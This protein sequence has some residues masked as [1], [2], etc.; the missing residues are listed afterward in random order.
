[1]STSHVP[2]AAWR[3]L[4]AGLLAGALDLCLALIVQFTVAHRVNLIRILQ[5]IA[6]GLLGPAARDGGVGSAS[7]GLLLHLSIATIWAG[8]Y[9]GAARRLGWLSGITQTL[10][11]RVTTG[12]GYGL[13]VWAGMNLVVVPLSRAQSG[14]G[15]NLATAMI[16][17]GHTLFVGLP[18]ALAIGAVKPS[19]SRG[20][21]PQA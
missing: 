21:S 4:R 15:L 3:V 1:M 2:S 10:R 13:V 6:S 16:L 18:I 9:F 5:A 8:I 20:A 7:L 11:A 17:V 12:L 19:G 14:L